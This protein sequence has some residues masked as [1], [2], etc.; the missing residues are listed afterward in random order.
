MT[1]VLQSF[2]LQGTNMCKHTACEVV[3][4]TAAYLSALKYSA[5]TAPLVFESLVESCYN[6]K[7]AVDAATSAAPCPLDPQ[8]EMEQCIKIL[9]IC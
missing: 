8:G 4:N 3:Q 2:T 9:N 5:K 6:F 7:G 1:F